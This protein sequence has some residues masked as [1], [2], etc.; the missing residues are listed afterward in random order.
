MALGWHLGAR[1]SPGAV[2][3]L[4]ALGVAAGRRWSRLLAAA[5]GGW[6]LAVGSVPVTGGELPDVT[7]PLEVVFRRQGEWGREAYGWGARGKVLVARQGY[8]V[9]DWHPRL[10]LTVAGRTSPP[11]ATRYRGIG[12]LSRSAGFANR[13]RLGPGPWRL[14]VGSPRFLDP[15]ATSPPIGARWRLLVR[16]R[17][18]TAFAAPQAGP[19]A[20]LARALLL[21]EREALGPRLMTALRRLGLSHLLALSGL[22]VG[23]VAGLAL[24]GARALPRPL[25]PIAAAGAVLTFLW[26]AGSSPSLVRASLMAVLALTALRLRRRPVAINALSLVAVGMVVAQPSVLD[27]VG[28][29]LSIAATAGI[30]VV[31]PRLADRWTVLPRPLARALATTVAA[32]LATLPVTVPLFRLVPLAAPAANLVA[33]PWMATTLAGCLFAGAAA[34]AAP[35]AGRMALA[36]VDVVAMPWEWLTRLPAAWTPTAV[37]LLGPLGATL[38]A[39]TVLLA[40]WWPRRGIP[41][42]VALL[43]VASAGRRSAVPPRVSVLDVGQGQAVLLQSGAEAVLVDGGGFRDFDL[44]GRVL[45]PALAAMGVRRLQAVTLSHADLDHCQGLL[46]L[47]TYLTVDEIWSGAAWPE[48]TCWRRLRTVPGLTWRLLRPGDRAEVGEWRLTALHPPSHWQAE[49]NDRSLVLRAVARGLRVLLP[50]D[51]QSRGERRLVAAVPPGSLRSDLLVVPHHGSRT[52][53]SSRLLDAVDPRLA[54][55]SAGVANRYHHPAPQV[56]L[57]LAERRIRVLRTDRD[58][59]VVVT[60]QG[61]GRSR[62][63]LPAA[64]R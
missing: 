22:H 36:A 49:D 58:G 37:P 40:L 25:Q 42:L 46:Q 64:P 32:Q 31:A 35:S 44:G 33:V 11:R 8:R 23:L 38:L 51:L 24:L 26:L 55:V 12:Y 20:A 3:L 29:G 13:P 41:I 62:V 50:G 52:S 43:L 16:S 21:G 54:I 39:A 18:R 60:A 6:L 19:G 53:S 14:R 15:V 7:R 56:L 10:H 9:L 63:R 47:A 48:S 34:L 61:Q 1:A 27:D 28:F 4:L 5:C 45:L 30:V 2:V 59:L 57:R 17:L